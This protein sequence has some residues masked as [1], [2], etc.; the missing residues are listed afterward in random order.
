MVALGAGVLPALLLPIASASTA[1]SSSS[2]PSGPSDWTVYHGKAAGTGVAAGISSVDTSS[3]AWT[4]PALDG[5]VYGEPLVYSGKV[6]VA[7]ETDVVYALSATNGSI[8]WSTH[9]ADPVPSHYLPC[10]DIDPYLGITGTPVIDPAR[11]E[12]FAVADEYIDDKP[13]HVLVGID[14]ASGAIQMHQDVDPPGADPAALL[15][16]T[17]LNL[18]GGQVVFGMG[19]NYGDCASYRGRVVAAPE[20]GGNPLFFSVD[21]APS[22]SQGAIWMGGGAPAVA[23]N[24]NIWV[25]TGNG[26]VHSPGGAYDDSDAALELSPTLRLIQFFAP[27]DWPENNAADLDMSVVP[28]LLQNGEVLLAGKSRI[29]YL[30]DGAK[31]G[32]VGGQLASTGPVCDQDIDGGSA[33]LGDVVY[34][35][36]TSG[37]VAVRASAS[38]ASLKLLWSSGTGGGPP[39]VAAGLVWTIGSNGVLYGLNP[40]TG[41]VRQRA[42]VGSVANHFPTP[43]VG[44]GLLLAPTA[45]GVVAFK[46]TTPPTTTTTTSTTAS[47]ST[48]SSSVTTSSSR[49][50]ASSPA[51]SGHGG[52][53]VGAAIGGI[54]AALLLSALAA[55]VIFRRRARRVE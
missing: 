29:V 48:S 43:S 19:G 13:S 44:D 12:L 14:T 39:I 5:Q 7:T 49:P 36:C 24:G 51:S 52:S 1:S 18:D 46:A 37:T 9:V 32:G 15:Q 3:P 22:E 23:G 2:A 34:L 20:S 33:A 42:D 55:A 41:A 31:L 25:S 8:V 45:N 11:R 6:Y 10:G 38:P 54:V 30:L 26:S 47:T 50:P 17:G 16:R 27:S 21:A 4:S 53:A 35:P 28:V 40:S